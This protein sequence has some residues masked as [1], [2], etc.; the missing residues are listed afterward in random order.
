MDTTT[1]NDETQEILSEP[2]EEI[3][4]PKR[5]LPPPPVIDQQRISH[6]ILTQRDRPI[7]SLESMK[8]YLESPDDIDSRINE[9]EQQHA[10][11]LARLYTALAEEYL[12]EAEDRYYSLD[13]KVL[14][15]DIKALYWDLH[16]EKS[17]PKP[18][19]GR[20]LE[21]TEIAYRSRMQDLTRHIKA[22][23]HNRKLA[24]M[25]FPQSIANYHLKPRDTQH[26]AARFLVLDSDEHRDK[27]MSEF[28]WAWRQVNPLKREYQANEEFQHEIRATVAELGSIFDYRKR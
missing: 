13:E 16:G 28:G 25:D 17:D 23:E 9:L 1:A 21:H 19:W 22:R 26:R 24:E 6:Y 7:S 2:E 8:R 27:M 11:D 3:Y 5:P 4:G 18:E 20:A 15:N 12:D 10:D 14:H